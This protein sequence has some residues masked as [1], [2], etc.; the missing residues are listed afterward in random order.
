MKKKVIF[1]QDIHHKTKLYV[2]IKDKSYEN[3]IKC[4]FSLSLEMT[5][6]NA[7]RNDISGY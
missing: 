5:K 4:R 6:D 3:I 1:T 2:G 7:T